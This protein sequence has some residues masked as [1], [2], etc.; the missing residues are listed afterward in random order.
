MGTYFLAPGVTFCC[1]TDTPHGLIFIERQQ[2][3]AQVSETVLGLHNVFKQLVTP[4]DEA[5][6]KSTDNYYAPYCEIC[7]HMGCV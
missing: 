3:L 4:T 2:M 7:A 6:T 1:I 5:Q